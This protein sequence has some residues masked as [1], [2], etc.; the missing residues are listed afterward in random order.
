MFFSYAQRGMTARN[1][2]GEI[3]RH[4]RGRNASL[5]ARRGQKRSKDKAKIK[6]SSYSGATDNDMLKYLLSES[7][8]NTQKPLAKF[9]NTRI[10]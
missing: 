7:I 3:K 4:D 2:P 8:K 1:L 9:K 5:F 10:K 6:Q